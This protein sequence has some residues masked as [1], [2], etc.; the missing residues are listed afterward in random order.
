MDIQYDKTKIEM[1]IKRHIANLILQ[2]Q[3]SDVFYKTYVDRL[4][5]FPGKRTILK[6]NLLPNS[7]FRLLN[8]MAEYRRNMSN[9]VESCHE[10]YLNPNLAPM[11]VSNPFSSPKGTKNQTRQ[12]MVTRLSVSFTVSINSPAICTFFS[13][14]ISSQRDSRSDKDS[15]SSGLTLQGRPNCA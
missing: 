7:L 13:A 5:V 12:S 11:S 14:A 10:G 15:H 8:Q 2:D 1:D 3:F 9:Q 4:L 6:L